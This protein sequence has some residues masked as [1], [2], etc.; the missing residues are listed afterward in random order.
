MA[1]RNAAASRDL[2]FHGTRMR[3]HL[4]TSDTGG[5]YALIEMWHPPSV[6]PALHVHPRGPESFLVLA[7]TYAFTRGGETIAA[8]AGMAVVVPAG[9][10]HRYEVGAEGGHL[11]VIC[12]PG[13]EEYFEGV[14]ALAERGKVEQEVEFGIAIRCGQEFL[15]RTGHWGGR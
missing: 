7:G 3:L 12:P 14:A 2:T 10:A 1:R 4:R 13:L 5:A 11:L 9:V 6:G 8:D 15:D